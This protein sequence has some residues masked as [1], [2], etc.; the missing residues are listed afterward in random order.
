MGLIEYV[1]ALIT[2]DYLIVAI[3]NDEAADVARYIHSYCKKTCGIF[4]AYNTEYEI[5]LKLAKNQ[6][7]RVITLYEVSIGTYSMDH[8]LSLF[9]RTEKELHI[10]V[11][12]V[13]D[14]ATLVF[15]IG[16]HTP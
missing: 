10:P 2:F 12:S 11:S 13:R 16:N 1:P 8:L 7:K 14:G 6:H 4:I 3:N 5:L 15:L 9:N